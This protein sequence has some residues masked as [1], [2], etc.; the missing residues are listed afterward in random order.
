MPKYKVFSGLGG[1]FGGARDNEEI[2]EFD[3]EN[4]AIDYAYELAKEEYES[5]AGLHGLRDIKDIMDEDGV[6]EEEAEEIFCEE[7][8][9]WLDYYVEEVKEE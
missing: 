9:N 7:R 4:E 8:E 3:N 6:D 2:Y 1:G 5:Y